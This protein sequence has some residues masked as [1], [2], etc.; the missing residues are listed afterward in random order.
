VPR[1]ELVPDSG[2]SLAPAIRQRAEAELGTLGPVTVHVGAAAARAADRLDASAYT[3]GNSIVFAAGA[4]APQTTA[5]YQL[6]LHELVH[7]RQ[8][9]GGAM[10]HRQ[11]RDQGPTPEQIVRDPELFTDT[12]IDEFLGEQDAVDALEADAPAAMPANQAQTCASCHPSTSFDFH[13]MQPQAR[14]WWEPANTIDDGEDRLWVQGPRG[15]RF[16]I[17]GYSGPPRTKYTKPMA[18]D[19]AAR[20]DYEYAELAENYMCPTC[21]VAAQVGHTP[22]PSM[23]APTKASLR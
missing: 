6:M 2:A 21:H 18:I 10:V 15:E 13:T 1:G 19:A 8:D 3:Y 14:P 9:P 12:M 11:P 17:N 23:L 7:T 20:G 4:Y 22:S 5:G 16:R